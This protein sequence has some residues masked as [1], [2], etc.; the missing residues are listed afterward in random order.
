[1]AP[2][3]NRQN[4]RRCE[5]S[6]TV[7]RPA[8]LVC[9]FLLTC[10]LNVE[11]VDIDNIYIEINDIREKLSERLTTQVEEQVRSQVR[12]K[13]KESVEDRV[14]DAVMET[15]TLRVRSTITTP[16]PRRNRAPIEYI[17]PKR[18]RARILDPVNITEPAVDVD[19]LVDSQLD[20]VRNQVD[21]TINTVQNHA[22][23]PALTN[24]WLVM[25][26]NVTLSRM[27]EEGYLIKNIEELTGLGYVLGTVEAPGSFSPENIAAVQV[28]YDP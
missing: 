12:A 24:E 14:N 3:Y 17:S 9:L 19:N 6:L 28:V 13:I 8:K 2:N 26:D 7:T 25:T 4:N 20:R 21:L 22:G 15:I 10:S 23:N 1:M 5:K 16:L 11:A 18:A 27:V